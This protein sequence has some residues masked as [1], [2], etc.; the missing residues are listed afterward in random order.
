MYMYLVLIFALIHV[1]VPVC[2]YD[3]FNVLF[4]RKF[5]KAIQMLQGD[6]E[7]LEAER[8]NLKREMDSQSNSPIPGDIS[9]TRRSLSMGENNNNMKTF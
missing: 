6:L 8:D 7:T 9:G 5:N 1:P 2:V 4:L 3:V